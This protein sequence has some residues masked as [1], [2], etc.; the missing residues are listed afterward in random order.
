MLGLI[1]QLGEGVPKDYVEAVRWY[2]LA[3]EQGDPGAQVDLAL[4]YE[5]GQ[6][7]TRDDVQAYMWLNLATARGNID[8]A[9]LR[10][11]LEA[12]MTPDQIAE[13]QRL[14]REWKP[15]PKHP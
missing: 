4:V 1:Y 6:G 9:K 12:G 10:N 2:R 13:A 14:A 7:V 8:A 5:R 15:K 11:V 3:A